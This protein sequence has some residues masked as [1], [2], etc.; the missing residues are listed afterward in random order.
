MNGIYNL[1]DTLI[2]KESE[3]I[4]IFLDVYKSDKGEI[5]AYF[6]QNSF[7]NFF[8]N[9][10]LLKLVNECKIYQEGIGLYI[11]FKLLNRWEFE[12]IDSTAINEKFTNIL[13][14]GQN[15][16][17]FI[18]GNFDKYDFIS[19]CD[20]KK[21]LIEDIFNGFSD[22]ENKEYLI[23]KI[24]IC[25]SR[26]ILLGLGTPKQELLAFELKKYLPDRVF[27]CVGNFMNFF[28][29]YQK[30]APKIIRKLNLEWLFRFFLEPVRLFRRY[31]IGVPL[32]FIRIFCLK[33]NLRC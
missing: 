10:L 30:R 28:L 14:Q 13:I 26:Y 31:I 18:G 16:I 32:F 1:I 6:N 21:L 11:L 22:L 2:K 25:N 4:N 3:I 5:F 7:N 17:I 29:N 12:R 23:K 24:K 9:N 15:S 27:I 33:F 20:N 8:K 19:R